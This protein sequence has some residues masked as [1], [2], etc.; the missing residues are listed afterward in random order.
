MSSFISTFSLATI[1]NQTVSTAQ[2]NLANVEQEL[3]TGVYADVG[4]TLGAETGQDMSLRSQ[5]SL[6][7][8]IGASNDTATTNL[9]ST[10]TILGN[11]QSTAQDF[12]QTLL[13]G[14]TSNSTAQSLQS[15]AQNNLQSLLSQLNT[16]V[17]GE[18]IFAG[19]NSSVAP[20]TDGTS[21]VASAY[22]SYL[23]SLA[24][25]SSTISASQMQSFLDTQ[26]PALFQGSNWASNWSSASDTAIAS[27]IS[28]TQTVVTSVSA[29]QSAFQQ[30]A[31]AYSM[32]ADLGTSN[33]SSTAYQTV[34]SSAE[35]LVQNSISGLTTIQAGLGAAQSAISTANDYMSTQMTTLSTQVGNLENVDTY[36]VS[37]QATELQTQIETAY[38]L[39]SQLQQ[40]SLVKY[41]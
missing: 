36:S 14:T 4:L 3:S 33:L 10:Q 39:T 16:N 37:T 26:Y 23:T 29:N 15:A 32:V 2:S 17:G 11:L 8:T 9:N 13:E 12:L 20:M 21:S 5:E 25:T 40:L 35:A 27:Q 41:L 28:P 18:Y 31:Q 34:V 7:Q 30:L 6:L 19:I 38:Q 24:A 22:S 1:L